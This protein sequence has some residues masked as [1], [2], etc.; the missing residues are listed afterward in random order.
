VEHELT[1]HL[2]LWGAAS[3]NQEPLL[4]QA[5]DH[6]K[7]VVQRS[8]KKQQQIII[9]KQTK[10]LLVKSYVG[11]CSLMAW[12]NVKLIKYRKDKKYNDFSRINACC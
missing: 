1:W 2:R 11:K 6:A 9:N 4:H 7:G 5:T 10:G 12:A 3:G 8:V